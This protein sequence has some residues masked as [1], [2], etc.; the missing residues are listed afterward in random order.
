MIRIV[1]AAVGFAPAAFLVAPTLLARPVW[2]GR[3]HG[4]HERTHA[5]A[6]EFAAKIAGAGR[7]GVR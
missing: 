4:D 6:A 7:N 5:R 1:Y 3:P 2:G